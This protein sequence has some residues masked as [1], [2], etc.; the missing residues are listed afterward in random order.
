MKKKENNIKHKYI[1]EITTAFRIFTWLYKWL[2]FGGGIL[3]ILV[4]AFFVIQYA[5]VCIERQKIHDFFDVAYTMSWY[6]IQ[7]H[8]SSGYI[9]SIVVA[10]ASLL[11]ASITLFQSHY[12]RARDRVLN[13][14]DNCLKVVSI[15]FDINNNIKTVRQFFN[16]LAG[17]TM[18]EFCFKKTFS[19]YYKAVPYRLF[20][21]L[22]KRVDGQKDEWEEIEIYN[23]Q[24]SNL[25][26]QNLDNYE[27]LLEGS[28]SRLLREYCNKTSFNMEYKLEMILDVK[29]ENCLM[30][31]WSRRFADIFIR[32][33]VQLNSNKINMNEQNKEKSLFDNNYY[34]F[35]N[36]HMRAPLL[37]LKHWRK[38]FNTNVKRRRIE[39]NIQKSIK[40]L[41]ERKEDYK[42]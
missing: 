4:G 19:S 7:E 27:I 13:F 28:P 15:G 39:R 1:K 30:P 23:Y 38:C 3:L 42:S 33:H 16:P 21:C 12:N 11:L 35:L 2:V 10:A 26:N 40:T 34:I 37:S 8:S 14:P 25:L 29:W 9:P 6:Q 32:E 36:A 41:E 31:L 5:V 24:S 18:I 22:D 17:S 20:I